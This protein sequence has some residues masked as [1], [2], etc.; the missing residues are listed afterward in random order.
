ML[1]AGAH[2]LD[3]NDQGSAR[4]NGTLTDL[5]PIRVELDDNLTP[6]IFIKRVLDAITAREKHA[7]L[8]CNGGHYA[9][10]QY[11]IRVA[12]LRVAAKFD[13]PVYAR[14][15]PHRPS[16]ELQLTFSAPW[17]V[18]V[19]EQLTFVAEQ[20][21]DIAD[22]RDLHQLAVN[23]LSELLKTGPA[24]VPLGPSWASDRCKQMLAQF[25]GRTSDA[26]ESQRILFFSA[27]CRSLESYIPKNQRA[28]PK[29]S[30][31]RLQRLW[32]TVPRLVGEAHE[33]GI[34]L[35]IADLFKNPTIAGVVALAQSSPGFD[36]N[37]NGGIHEISQEQST[38]STQRALNP[39]NSPIL[40]TLIR[41]RSGAH[42]LTTRLSHAQYDGACFC[43]IIMSVFDAYR[44]RPLAPFVDF[45]VYAPIAVGKSFKALYNAQS[46][47]WLESHC[48]RPNS[49]VR[50]ITKGESI[51]DRSQSCD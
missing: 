9:Q 3:P 8:I 4:V 5:T 15:A 47:P 51:Q 18:K 43:S 10:V 24:F 12:R 27:A 13:H 22:S 42:R 23:L 21:A 19:L 50:S 17:D 34:A 20:L 28:P 31:R 16:R 41:Q 38:K 1:R 30:E 33:S 25:A 32:V 29:K 40:F 7:A 14:Q 45:S 26:A 46:S 37:V 11:G 49:L 6:S 35:S 44:N 36:V 48:P 39:G 2:G